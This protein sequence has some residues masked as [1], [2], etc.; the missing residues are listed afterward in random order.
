MRKAPKSI[1]KSSPVYADGGILPTKRG[2]TKGRNISA[3]PATNPSDSTG[4]KNPYN[5]KADALHYKINNSDY[6]EQ[7]HDAYESTYNNSYNNLMEESY[8][9]KN[10]LKY[11][12]V[13]SSVF[14]QAQGQP[15]STSPR[16]KA[17]E[18]AKKAYTKDVQGIEMYDAATITKQAK[19]GKIGVADTSG[20][21]KADRYNIELGWNSK[22]K[23]KAVK[24][25]L[26]VNK[27]PKM[28]FGGF[29]PTDA[30][31]GGTGLAVA[32]SGPL[33]D[34]FDQPNRYGRQS[35]LG[36]GLKQ[37][38]SM[39]AAGAALGPV[40]AIA[41]GALGLGMG[42][43]G[44]IGAK[45]KEGAMDRSMA[46]EDELNLLNQ[47]QAKL[48][49]DPSLMYGNR[50]RQMFAKG[51]ELPTNPAANEQLVPMNSEAVEVQGPTHEEGGVQIPGA[52]VEDGE[53]ITKGFVFSEELGFAK[54]HK[55]I[56]QAMGKIEKKPM[57]NIRRK[58]LEH[59]QA[60]E[61]TLAQQ[62]EQT[63]AYLGIQ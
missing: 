54:L 44:S 21:T 35:G 42:L 63:K 19:A 60:K 25:T 15:M 51:G 61:E 55:P 9:K 39:A 13:N 38:A 28:K 59:L 7:P 5:R 57:T 4:F 58:T 2:V 26:A 17:V 49:S 24:E 14:P 32:A 22:N 31:T 18:D 50:G 10:F 8:A 47:G 45:R 62:Q 37:G 20:M 48:A 40:G 56:A 12:N 46:S 30:V 53:T 1:K 52:E 16:L 3:F 33:V 23:P 11:P 36:A 43:V 27:V 29:K 41:G 6:S 34:L